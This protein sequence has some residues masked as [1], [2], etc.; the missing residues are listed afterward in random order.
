MY[1]YHI[2]VSVRTVDA[3]Q[4]LE[5]RTLIISTVRTCSLLGDNEE[6]AG[7]LSNPKVCYNLACTML[8]SFLS[9]EVCLIVGMHVLYKIFLLCYTLDHIYS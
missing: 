6:D 8:L 9:K 5:F 4:G 7:F 2:Q 3:V 1:I